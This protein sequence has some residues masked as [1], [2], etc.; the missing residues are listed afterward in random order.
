MT[1]EA[2]QFLQH[3]NELKAS[4]VSPET[5]SAAID[6]SGPTPADSEKLKKH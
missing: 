1:I 2:I 3:Q 5:P 4:Q 6:K